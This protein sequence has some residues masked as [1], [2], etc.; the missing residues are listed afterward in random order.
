MCVAHVRARLNCA[1]LQAEGVLAVWLCLDILISLKIATHTLHTCNIYIH[2]GR[3][4]TNDIK[5]PCDGIFEARFNWI[6]FIS[7]IHASPA[8][9]WSFVKE[10]DEEKKKKKIYIFIWKHQARMAVVGGGRG[11]LSPNYYIR[12]RTHE[13]CGVLRTWDSVSRIL[14]WMEC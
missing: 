13:E 8:L 14:E 9:D 7:V 4:C 5:R 3:S 11:R 12:I 2:I 10:C 1:R 6:Q